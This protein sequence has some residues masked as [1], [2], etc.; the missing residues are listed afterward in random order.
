MISTL[1]GEQTNQIINLSGQDF[2]PEL[3]ISGIQELL[4]RNI[5]DEIPVTDPLSSKIS[6]LIEADVNNGSFVIGSFD[7]VTGFQTGVA[8]AKMYAGQDVPTFD[9]TIVVADEYSRLGYANIL[10]QTT[11]NVI[12]ESYDEPVRL[13]T[14]VTAVGEDAIAA[15]KLCLR[16]GM[17]PTNIVDEFAKI[18]APTSSKKDEFSIKDLQYSISSESTDAEYWPASGYG[19]YLT[20][21]IDDS[22]V[23][24]DL[25]NNPDTKGFQIGRAENNVLIINQHYPDMEGL[26]RFHDV[27]TRVWGL[28]PRLA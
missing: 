27:A 23:V 8:I 17:Y 12:A 26:A 18:T 7:P 20:Q 10:F 5:I 4:K 6:S 19:F 3:G 16:N 15:K 24:Y 11:E 9:I 25:G 22:I 2:A 13:T 21:D 1:T 28:K 14:I